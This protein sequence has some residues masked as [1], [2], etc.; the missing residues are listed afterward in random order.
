MKILAVVLVFLGVSLLPMVSFAQIRAAKLDLWVERVPVDSVVEYSCQKQRVLLMA[1]QEH[2]GVMSD[3][4]TLAL[5]KFSST[6]F[7]NERNKDIYTTMVVR[8]DHGFIIFITPLKNNSP[9]ATHGLILSTT[10]ICH[11]KN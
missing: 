10:N 9:V 11:G 7:L 6:F 5:T 1:D 4:D 3:T 8:Y 2:L